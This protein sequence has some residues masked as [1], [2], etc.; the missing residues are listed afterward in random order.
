MVANLAQLLVR[1]AR[2]HPG[3]PALARG[4]RPIATYGDLERDVA[5]LAGALRGRLG[6]GGNDRVALVMKNTPAYVEVLFACWHAG[7]AAVPINAKLHPREVAYIV[8]NA[9]ASVTFVTAGLGEGLGGTVI[10]V[11]GA[12]YRG[13]K[14]AERAPM[15]EPTDE[16]VA[17]LFYT[18]GT[19]GRPK[20]V[21]LTHRNLL[22]M[23]LC[24]FAD[25]DEIR[26]GDTILHAAPMSHGSGLY[27]VP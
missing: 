21:M 7:L 26:P 14:A 11:D 9:G 10:D 16:D 3:R 23:A 27:I 5:A 17:W 6:L 12:E 4:E 22:A 18:S 19:T 1:S 2:V 24:Y 13:L 25:V 20:G 15:A 8:E